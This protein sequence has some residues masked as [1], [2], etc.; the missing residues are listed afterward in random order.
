MKRVFIDE[1]C[2]QPNFDQPAEA[3]R[4]L[5]SSFNSPTQDR[6][7]SGTRHL[8]QCRTRTATTAP[9][10]FRIEDLVVMFLQVPSRV[11]VHNVHL[12]SSSPPPAPHLQHGRAEEP[13]HAEKIVTR[14]DDLGPCQATPGPQHRPE[15]DRASNEHEPA[16]EEQKATP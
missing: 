8:R 2:L 1:T 5:R 14:L 13:R 3:A 16:T 6:G 10:D 7:P 12:L 9:P 15:R 11:A 4:W